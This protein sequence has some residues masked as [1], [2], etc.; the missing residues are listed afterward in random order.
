MTNPLFT[1]SGIVKHNL[2]RGKQLGYPTANIDVPANTSEGIFAALVTHN[3]N[4]YQSVLFIGPSVTFN[5]TDKKAEVYI[6]DFDKDIYGEYLSVHVLK[7]LRENEKF[8]TVEAL[9]EKMKKD[10]E[11]AREFFKN[12]EK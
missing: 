6:L 5:E 3:T 1:F 10:E 8:T 11:N 4:K 12:L 9:I 2:G 7:K